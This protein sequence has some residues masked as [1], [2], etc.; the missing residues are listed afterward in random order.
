MAVAETVTEDKDSTVD[1]TEAIKTALQLTEL[2]LITSAAT[3]AILCASTDTELVD[4]TVAD[5]S[6]TITAFAETEL[7][8][9][10]SDATDTIFT[11][12]VVTELV[13]SI[14]AD[15]FTINI[16]LQETEDEL[17]TFAATSNTPPP[18]M[19]EKGDCENAL[20]P[21]II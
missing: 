16:A 12:D 15:T 3:N 18:S 1:D 8:E 17:S 4:A 9:E 10:I 11:T 2:P 19:E 13:A 7:S 20:N 5:I 14:A 21:S 6:L